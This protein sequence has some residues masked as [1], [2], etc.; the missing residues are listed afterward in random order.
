MS[1]DYR[2]CEPQGRG[3]L[4]QAGF[5]LIEL[6][7][8]LSVL[9]ILIGLLL[10]AVQAAREAARR[11]QC[12]N[13]LKQI[14]LAIHAYHDANGSLPLCRFF[15]ADPAYAN[16]KAPCRSKV[17]DAGF[18]VRILTDMDQGALYN[19]VNQDLWIHDWANHTVLSTSVGIFTCP[20]DTESN[21]IKTGYPFARLP[22]FDGDAFRDSVPVASSSYAGCHGSLAIDVMP[23]WV[24]GTCSI[25]V[26]RRR[27]VNGTLNAISPITFASIRDGLSQTM[28]VAE[29]ATTPLLELNPHLPFAFEQR[30]WWTGAHFGDSLFAAM[31]PPNTFQRLRPSYKVANAWIDSAGSLHPGGLNVLMADGSVRFIKESIDSWKMPYTRV[32]LSIAKRPGVWQALATRS[33]GEVMPGDVRNQ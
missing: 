8:V 10:P 26:D 2:R 24:D 28:L 15:T 16:P 32:E 11:A 3:R 20:S 7:V 19:A 5:T 14:G 27:W 4:R 30:G 18:L 33:G 17:L 29:Q 12:A 1:V 22:S 13:N 31:H 25:R 9:S 21:R 6:L 23:A